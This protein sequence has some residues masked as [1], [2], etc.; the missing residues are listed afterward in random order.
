MPRVLLVVHV[1]HQVIP[2]VLYESGLLLKREL[3]L[4]VGVPPAHVVGDVHHVVHENL[5]L[6]NEHAR[7]ELE[8]KSGEFAATTTTTTVREVRRS[9][10]NEAHT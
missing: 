3:L 10:V 1:P 7:G 8:A 9:G 2:L 6:Q 4:G 5:R